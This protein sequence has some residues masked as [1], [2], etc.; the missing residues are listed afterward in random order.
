[1]IS[2]ICFLSWGLN[3]VDC[4]VRAE[5]ATR[6]SRGVLAAWM[7]CWERLPFQRGSG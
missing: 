5:R 2:I 6:L 4:T 3:A 7:L 1:M